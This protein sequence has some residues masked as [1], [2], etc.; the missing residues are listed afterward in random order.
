MPSPQFF[1]DTIL[2]EEERLYRLSELMVEEQD[3]EKLKSLPDEL[4]RLLSEHQANQEQ[5]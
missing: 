5:P 2:D 1:V 4:L 3:P